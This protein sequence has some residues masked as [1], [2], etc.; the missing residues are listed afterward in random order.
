MTSTTS[1]RSFLLIRVDK[2]KKYYFTT[3]FQLHTDNS[4]SAEEGPTKKTTKDLCEGGSEFKFSLTYVRTLVK[5]DKTI[6]DCISQVWIAGFAF[7]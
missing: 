3:L 1:Y 2:T 7:V 5:E 4:L 6:Q